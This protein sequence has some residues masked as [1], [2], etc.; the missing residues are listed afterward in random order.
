MERAKIDQ[1]A[2]KMWP[3]I[4]TP[5]QCQ[6]ENNSLTYTDGAKGKTEHTLAPRNGHR[7]KS[8]TL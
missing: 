2:R 1:E 3:I 7:G 6:E 8:A 5:R 4:S